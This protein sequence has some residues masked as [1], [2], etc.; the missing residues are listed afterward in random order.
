MSDTSQESSS[1]FSPEVEAALRQGGWFPGRQVAEEKMAKWYVLR[2]QA[3]PG[4]CRI[5]PAAYRFLREFGGTHLRMEYRVPQKSGRTHL[6]TE[7]CFIDPLQTLD[8]NED[9]WIYYEWQIETSLYPLG[10][11]DTGDFLHIDIQGRFWSLHNSSGDPFLYGHTTEEALA[12][13]LSLGH[14]SSHPPKPIKWTPSDQLSEELIER[15]V[16]AEQRVVPLP[17]R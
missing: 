17:K 7:S 3:T 4:Y 10:M 9:L 11:W 2:W 15:I 6:V 5:F 14:Y 12:N 1:R 13:M 16:E 8:Y